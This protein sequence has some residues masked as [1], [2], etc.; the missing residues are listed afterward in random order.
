MKL[1]PAGRPALLAG[2]ALACSFA[3]MSRAL[4]EFNYGVSVGAGYS[5]NIRRVDVGETDEKMGTLGL[6]LTWLERTQ[7]I[8]ADVNVDLSYFEYLDNTYDSEVVGIADGTVNLAIIPDRFVWVFQD[9]FGQ[10]QSDPFAPITPDNRENLN[11]FT[12]GPDFTLRLGSA[13]SVRVFGRYSLTNYETSPL[14]A[15]RR[16]A[17]IALVRAISESSDVSLNYTAEEV[18]FD[19]ALSEDYDRRSAYLNYTIDGARTRIIA[20]LGQSWLERDNDNQEDSGALVDIT[21]SRDISAS[22]TLR[23]SVAKQFTD[24]GSALRGQLAG[25]TAGS[26]DI[27]ATS[28]PF[29]NRSVTVGWDFARNRTGISLA[30]SWNEDRYE[31]QTLLDRTRK[32]YDANVSRQMSRTLQLGLRAMFTDEEYDNTG[33]SSDELNV[34]ASLTFTPGRLIDY[35]LTFDRYDRDTSNGTG[36]FV[37]NRAFFTV[38][39]RP[40]GR[41]AAARAVRPVL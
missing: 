21:V 34:G 38:T 7:R 28:D 3:G 39:V 4:A 10:A 25:Q 9:S 24:A 12:T 31:E 26:P 5:D 2:L 14:D 19:N 35:S 23:L 13:N 15:D 16:S 32:V 6:D 17:G 29:E 33:L 11:Y 30:A 36:E 41:A 18:D 22:S 20:N 8:D 40:R 37:E 27:T 1:L